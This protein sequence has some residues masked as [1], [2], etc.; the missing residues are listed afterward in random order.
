MAREYYQWDYKTDSFHFYADPDK[1]IR[2]GKC[3][4]VCSTQIL[5]TDE[6]GNVIFHEEEDGHV[7][8]GGC[9][10]CQRCFAVCPTG[11]I[12]IF[13]RKPEDSVHSD[14]A[15]T[16]EQFS[17]L[18]RTRRSC[19]HFKDQELPREL[20]NE[21]LRELENMPTSSGLQSLEFAVTYDKE[22]TAKFRR[23]VRESA[24]EY[25]KRGIFP[26]VFGPREFQNQLDIEPGRNQGDVFM[27]HA[28]H[29]LIISSKKQ[30]ALWQYDPHFADV[31]WDLICASKGI[32]SLFMSLPCAVL[33][34]VPEARELLGLPETRHFDMIMGFGYPATTFAR[35]VQRENRIPIRELRFPSLR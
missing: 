1:C 15:A 12:T 29:M 26:G 7:G 25:A 28:P 22:E 23:F 35:G 20:I 30:T 14:E 2:C 27:S 33:N 32:G 17:A 24:L 3:M 5:C 11:A 10:R 31:Y 4:S 21:M 18:I 19:R 9:Y 8:W 16:F 6:E 34:N 13:D